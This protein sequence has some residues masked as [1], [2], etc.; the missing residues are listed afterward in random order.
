M[1]SRKSLQQHASLQLEGVK[2]QILLLKYC[3]QILITEVTIHM[4]QFRNSDW[5]RAVHGH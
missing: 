5:L 4:K 1:Q 2:L 3:V